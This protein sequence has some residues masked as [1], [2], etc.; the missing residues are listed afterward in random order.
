VTEYMLQNAEP[1]QRLGALEARLDPGTIQLLDALGNLEEWRCLEV[2]AGAGSIASWLAHRV[3]PRGHV[4]ATDLD[5]RHCAGPA[6]ASGRQWCTRCGDHRSAILRR[7][8]AIATRSGSR[9]RPRACWPR[10]QRGRAEGVM[11]Q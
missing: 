6:L 7:E 11:R 5:L 1:R 4:L 10:R 8:C 2:G 9:A 3:G